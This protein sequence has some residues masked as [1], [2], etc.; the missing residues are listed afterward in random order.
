MRRLCGTW[1][2]GLA[3]N[4]KDWRRLLSKNRKT[5][6]ENDDNDPWLTPYSKGDTN[7]IE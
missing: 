6:T 2:I 5:M 3:V 4:R 1:W 7:H